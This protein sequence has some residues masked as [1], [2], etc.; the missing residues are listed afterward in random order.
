MNRKRTKKC[1]ER[2]C[3]LILVCMI[4][5]SCQWHREPEQVYLVSAM[6]FDADEG[7]IRVTV[8][9]PV[10]E[11]QESSAPKTMLF[12]QTGESVVRALE[13][14]KTG[15]SKELV[16]SHCALAVLGE[17]LSKEQMQEVFAFSGTGE[18]IP[19]AA[20]VVICEDAERLLSAENISF[21]AIGYEV[22]Q[23]LERER[24]QLGIE[25]PC[26]IYELRAVASPDL[27]VY[28]PRF[29]V[30][31]TETSQPLRFEGVDIL[32]PHGDAFQLSAEECVFHA[33]LTD[34]YVGGTWQGVRLER[35]RSRLDGQMEGDDFQ[36]YLHLQMETQEKDGAD[37][38]SVRQEFCERAERLFQRGKETVGEDLFLLMYRLKQK[39]SAEEILQCDVA[40]EKI[41]L[42][43]TCEVKIKG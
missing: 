21:T 31:D 40:L 18:G 32:R 6:G 34:T 37:V 4:L 36:I 38:E 13:T 7:N 9:I 15:F 19:L 39:D 1:V 20:E 29:E 27:P 30:F 43:V 35:V 16:F 33:V 12:T 11:E 14:L 24:E 23:I 3:C 22:P 28:I 10:V 41:T 42:T 8:E 26:Q 17:T 5:S 2:M 25:L